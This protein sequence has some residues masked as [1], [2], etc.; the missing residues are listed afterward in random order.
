MN[1]FITNNTFNTRAFQG[2]VNKFL[3]VIG[4]WAADVPNAHEV[5]TKSII[6]PLLENNLIRVNEIKWFTP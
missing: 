1:E 6:K 2:A 5:F 4:N 3:A